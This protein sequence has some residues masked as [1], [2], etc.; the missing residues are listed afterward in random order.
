MR[1]PVYTCHQVVITASQFSPEQRG[2]C[3]LTAEWFSAARTL[4]NE[5]IEN[6]L[7]SM[8]LVGRKYY[9]SRRRLAKTRGAIRI[10]SI[11]SKGVNAVTPKM[12]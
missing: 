2:K 5:I 8:T 10:P 9:P 4:G 1:L 12:S 11:S 7:P 6:Y 3:L